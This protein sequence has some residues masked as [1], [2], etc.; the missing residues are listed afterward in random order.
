MDRLDVPEEF[1][2]SHTAQDKGRVD[3][4]A[5]FLIRH[6]CETVG[7]ADL[8]ETDLLDV[9]CGTKFA[10]AFVNDRIPV[11]SYVGLDVYGEMIDFL[12]REVRDPR[13]TFV[14]FD[15]RNELYNPDAPPMTADT[16]LGIGAQSFDLI[17]LFSVF[18]HLNPD[19]F[20]TMMQ[21][22]RRYVRDDGTLFFTAYLNERS[23]SGHGATERFTQAIEAAKAAGTLDPEVASA[24]EAQRKDV[25][26]FVD[27]D[28]ARPLMIAM[29]R[30]D[31]AFELIEGTGWKVD[32][33]L[34]PNEYAQHQF[35]CSPH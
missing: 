9:G 22:L 34:P 5:R 4:S 21:I 16:D 6:V 30:R 19:D 31:Y 13:F 32:R 2:R 20:R 12:R 3:D 26:R 28:P 8:S 29:Y 18:T 27:V 1:R 11:R 25:P 23:S 24:L 15:V 10:S 35:V 7:L 33:V 17:W 14:H